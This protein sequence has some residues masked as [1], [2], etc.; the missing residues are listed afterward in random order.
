ML[1]NW[2][3]GLVLRGLG[4]CWVSLWV[5]GHMGIWAALHGVILGFD[6]SGQSL[7]G[8]AVFGAQDERKSSMS[9]RL[10]FTRFIYLIFFSCSTISMPSKAMLM[11]LSVNCFQVTSLVGFAR[12]ISRAMLSF[13]RFHKY[14]GHFQFLLCRT[15]EK[16]TSNHKFIICLSIT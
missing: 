13:S 7:Q 15:A 14:N 8:D 2:I 5:H 9:S 10:V 6:D 3:L 16:R 11:W 12:Q 4:K 1:C